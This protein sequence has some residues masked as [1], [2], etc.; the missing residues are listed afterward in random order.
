[1]LV[2]HPGLLNLDL[3]TPRMVV[4]FWFLSLAVGI[5]AVIM[6]FSRDIPLPVR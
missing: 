4:L 5:L 2:N 6:M 1:M 3:K